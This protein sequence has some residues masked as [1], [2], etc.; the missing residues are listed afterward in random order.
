MTL[1]DI[2]A[3]ER[4]AELE[5]E[6]HDLSGMNAAVFDAQGRRVTS[7]VSWANA[8][9]PVIK[10]HPAGLSAIC[11]CANQVVAAEAARSGQPVVE[12]CDAGLAKIAV[13]VMVG[14]ACL[15]TV[16]CC[17]LLLDNGR[18]DVEYVARTLGEDPQVVARLAG[19]LRSLNRRQAEHLA[20][21]IEARVA[22]VVRGL[23]HDSPGEA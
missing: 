23:E 17:G 2:L 10:G 18:P 13:P 20:G 9:C 1:L 16:G 8:L 22:E 7:F 21:C 15:G 19:G 11:A 4:W 5:R 12:E 14:G 6:L 3:P